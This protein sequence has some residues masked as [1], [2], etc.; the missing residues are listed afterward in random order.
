MASTSSTAKLNLAKQQ[1]ARADSNTADEENVFIWSFWGLE[2]AIMAAADHAA[3]EAT[4]QHWAKGE[5]ARKLARNHGLPDVC[6]LL[7]DL[8]DARKS[9]AYDDTEA[10]DLDPL[11]VLASFK[12][13]LER[14]TEFLRKKP[15]RGRST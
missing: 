10:P 1:F 7:R 3:I 2:N 9:V 6:D 5:A 8:N 15:K 12:D 11:E 4:K 13:Y 14:V